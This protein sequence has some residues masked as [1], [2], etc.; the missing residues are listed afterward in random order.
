LDGNP[1]QSK[2][3]MKP[4]GAE[5]GKMPQLWKWFCD[6]RKNLI[7]SVIIFLAGGPLIAVGVLDHYGEVILAGLFAIF[8]SSL[9]IWKEWNYFCGQQRRLKRKGG[10]DGWL[11][12]EITTDSLPVADPANP[13]SGPKFTYDLDSGTPAILIGFSVLVLVCLLMHILISIK[14]FIGVTVVAL[15]IAAIVCV[16]CLVFV[17]YIRARSLIEN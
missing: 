8:V 16:L 5:I 12:N 1:R 11:E 7:L 9:A 3:L 2:I 4:C 13:D 10:Q 14:D 17:S 15:D 6:A